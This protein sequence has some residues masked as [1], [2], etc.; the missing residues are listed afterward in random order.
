MN[1]SISYLFIC[2]CIFFTSCG[3]AQNKDAEYNWDAKMKDMG[4]VDVSFWEP[5]IKFY[6]VYSTDENFT[7][8]P[9]YNSTLTRPWL[10]AKAAK[11]LIYAQELLKKEKPDL[12]IYIFDAARP[13]EVQYLMNEWAKKNKKEYYVANPEKGG[14]LH[15]YGMAVDVTLVDKYGDLLPMGTP[16]DF[17]GPEANINKEDD[18]L[19]RKRITKAE[20][21]NRRFLRKIMEKAG[22]TKVSS[23]WW[24]FNACS[25]DEAKEK[26]LLIER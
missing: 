1:R 6:I 7:G 12:S 2:L 14:S 13:V 19:K 9:L 24:H 11:M 20:Y 25:R 26:Y 16:F 23:E 5:T 18:L 17:F 4:F 21:D 15:N 3:N 8:K 10:Q 22:F